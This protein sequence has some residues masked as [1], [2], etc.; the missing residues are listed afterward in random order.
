[1]SY[2]PSYSTSV[3]AVTERRRVNTMHTDAF[4]WSYPFNDPKHTEG[5]C[6]TDERKAER[7]RVQVD[8]LK[9]IEHHGNQAVASTYGG[10]PR[11][12]L[13]VVGFGMASAWPYW[14]PRP[15]VLLEGPLG[16]EWADWL[17]LTGVKKG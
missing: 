2:T 10:W 6:C 9:E 15:T 13:P 14:T 3:Q 8:R 7:L 1:M 5:W 16:V 4:D 11:I 17:S 12:W